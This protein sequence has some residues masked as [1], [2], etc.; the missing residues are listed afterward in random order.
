MFFCKG[1]FPVGKKIGILFPHIC[2]TTGENC[3]ALRVKNYVNIDRATSL[4]FQLKL[5]IR[6]F[7]N[8]CHDGAESKWIKK[9]Y[10]ISVL[11]HSGLNKYLLQILYLNFWNV[12]KK[13]SIWSIFLMTSRFSFKFQQIKSKRWIFLL[14]QTIFTLVH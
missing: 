13:M 8:K 3:W 7:R 10:S 1:T 14:R 2:G 4:P 9:A 5:Y 11:H 12:F 6:D